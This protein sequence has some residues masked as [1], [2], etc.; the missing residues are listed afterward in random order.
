MAGPP[1]GAS[2]PGRTRSGRPGTAR[3]GTGPM[4]TLLKVLLGGNAAAAVHLFRGQ[5]ARFGDACRRAFTAARLTPPR[6][7]AAGALAQIPEIGLGDLLGARKPVIQLQVMRYED[8]M[9]PTDQAMT[10]L[11]LLVAEAPRT[12]LEIGTFM[13]HTTRQMAENLPEATVHTVDL[14]PD[15]AE[16]RGPASP[17]PKDDPHL[18]ARRVVGREYRDRACAARIVQHL[19]DTATWDFTA[20]GRPGFFFIDGAH[21]YEYCRNDSEKCFALGG[22]RGVFVWHDCDEAHPGVVRFVTEWRQQGRDIRRI[23]GTTFAYWQGLRPR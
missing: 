11:A 13:G 15:Y 22:G 7:S 18:I 6:S 12:V 17:L 8:G 9:L 20:A 14:P 2:R 23:A 19:A 3:A 1:A 4:K 21:T 5:P 10:L 16:G